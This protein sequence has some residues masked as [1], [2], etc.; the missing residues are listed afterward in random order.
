M[1]F[2]TFAA[3]ALFMVVSGGTVAEWREG[4]SQFNA[5]YSSKLQEIN[6]K[7]GD[8]GHGKICPRST[9]NIR[10]KDHLQDYEIN[11][12]IVDAEG[13]AAN[14][15][16]IGDVVFKYHTSLTRTGIQ[17]LAIEYAGLKLLEGIAGIP[18][19]YDIE[20]SNLVGG[21][22]MARLFVTSSAGSTDLLDF[23][24]HVKQDPSYHLHLMA[25]RA[26]E[27]LREVHKR[28]IVHGDVHGRNIMFEP[29]ATDIA[30]SLTFI[31][32]GRAH[33]FLDSDGNP[34]TDSGRNAI[35]SNFN[36]WLLSP[37]ELEGTVLS[38][39]DDL[40]RL[41]E[42]FLYGG[43]YAVQAIKTTQSLIDRCPK[44]NN[45]IR[46]A[47]VFPKLAQLKRNRPFDENTPILFKDLYNLIL[48]LDRNDIIDYD[49]WAR[50]FRFCADTDESPTRSDD[51]PA[52]HC[53][54]GFNDETNVAPVIDGKSETTNSAPIH[55]IPSGTVIYVKHDQS[56]QGQDVHPQFIPQ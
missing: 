41:V 21:F 29:T 3:P 52:Y 55:E 1:R 47:C 5:L 28:G 26:I 15:Y 14:I 23:T 45:D 27:I 36:E 37:W 16:K 35:T 32:F 48:K 46:A 6:E 51:P 43:G 56:S 20:S 10:L 49:E 50:R 8:I 54:Y 25:A 44:Y 9:W 7:L 19:V 53:L 42:T 12:K 34:L 40:I 4:I 30:G 38:R 17:S 13:S 33:P 11:P 24:K 39:R 18:R 2:F 31:D 22:C